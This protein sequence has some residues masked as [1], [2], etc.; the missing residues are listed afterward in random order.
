MPLRGGETPHGGPYGK[1]RGHR[2]PIRHQPEYQCLNVKYFFNFHKKN[3]DLM[4]LI[5][6][7]VTYFFNNHKTNFMNQN[8]F[9][10]KPG[11]AGGKF[12]VSFILSSLSRH[13][14]NSYPPAPPPPPPTPPTK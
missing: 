6:S 5:I 4:R 3:L 7:F 13:T 9:V 1:R 12:P 10:N 8:L 11:R 14:G 2:H